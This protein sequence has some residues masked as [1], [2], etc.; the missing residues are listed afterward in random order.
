MSVPL[1]GDQWGQGGEV[2]RVHIGSLRRSQVYT[3]PDKVNA[4]ASA[5]KRGAKM[6]PIVAGKDGVVHDGHNRLEAAIKAGHSTIDVR[7]Y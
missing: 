2:R 7:F 1:N 3:S 4:F 5:Y 6:P